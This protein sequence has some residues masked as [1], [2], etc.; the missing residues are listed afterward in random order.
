MIRGPPISTRTDTLFPYTTLSRSCEVVSP[1]ADAPAA[2][3]PGLIAIGEAACVSLHG[4]NRLG[5]NSLLDLVVFGRAASIRAAELI[6]PGMTHKPLPKDAGDRAI[7]RLDRVRH[8]RQ[9]VRTA[10]LR[11]EMQRV[12]QNDCAVFRTGEVLREGAEDRKSTRLNSSH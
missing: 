12:M 11:L 7:A 9:E 8:N 10:D 1:P 3:V 6:Q 4:A 2:V 5:S